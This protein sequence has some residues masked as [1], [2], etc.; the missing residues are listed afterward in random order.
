[1]SQPGSPHWSSLRESPISLVRILVT[2]GAGFIG[3][4]LCAELL[5]QGESVSILDDFNDFYAPSIKRGN[6][7]RLQSASVYE[8]DIRDPDFVE[9]VVGRGRF[10]A[11][12]HLAARAG[13]RPSISEPRLYIDTNIIGTQNLLDAS[14]RAGL[15]RFLFA[16]S[17]S[18]YAGANPP[19]T[20]DTP[21]TRTLS[22]Y[23]ATKLAGEHLC[24]IHAHLYQTQVICLRLF[25]VYGPGQRPDLAIHKFTRAIDSGTQ[26]TIY[27][28]GSAERDFTHVDDIVSGFVAAL[29]YSG[30]RFD[31]FNLGGG[32]TTTLEVL[33][34]MIERAADKTAVVDYR[35]THPGDMSVTSA[36]ITKA[37]VLL[38]YRPATR[39][40]DGIPAFVAWYRGNLQPS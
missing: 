7:Q 40:A 34:R 33:V 21:L 22:P 17:S 12:I 13:V 2:G 29:R 31:T 26:V 16:S 25:T 14:R 11:I 38:G 36:D 4:H 32:E 1:M 8:G 15:A 9:S 10:D 23:A 19:F 37:R 24:A 6:V 30:P 27:G 39:I 28:D 18:L 3:S 20:E 5:K 35:P